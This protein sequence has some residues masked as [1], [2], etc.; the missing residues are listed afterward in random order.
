MLQNTSYSFY[1]EKNLMIVELTIYPPG[2]PPQQVV[3]EITSKILTD[4]ERN[5]KIYRDALYTM[6]RRRDQQQFVLIE[7]APNTGFE[8]IVPK[9]PRYSNEKLQQWRNW[10][11]E[12]IETPQSGVFVTTLGDTVTGKVKVQLHQHTRTGLVSWTLK[13]SKFKPDELGP[14]INIPTSG[15]FIPKLQDA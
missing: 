4:V 14:R 8:R 10:L 7:R 5:L 6:L 12:S 11:L 3:Y 9:N 13:P 1:P 15:F 2:H